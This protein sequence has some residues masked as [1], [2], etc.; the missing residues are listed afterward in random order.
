MASR[1]P[2]AAENPP[3]AG[4]R[5]AYL[6]S[7]HPSNLSSLPFESTMRGGVLLL[8]LTLFLRPCLAQEVVL[9]AA[10]DLGYACFRIPAMVDGAP[11]ELFAFAEGRR[12]GCADFGDVDILMRR[13][14]DGGA[15][16]SDPTVVVD[17]GELQAGNPTP[18]L[19]RMDPDHPDGRLFLFF[20][21]GTASEYDTRL[22]LGRRRGCFTT[23]TDHGRT[24]TEPV[25]ISRQVHFDAQGPRPEVDAR[26]LAFAPGH[27]LQLTLG[28]HAGRLFVPANHSLGPPQDDFM[29]YRTYGAYSDDHGRSWQVSPDL[30]LP[31]SNEAMAAQMPDGELLLLVRMQN[32]TDRRKVLAMSRDGGASWDSIWTA[33]A[34]TTPMCQSSLL[35]DGALM[36]TLHLGPADTLARTGLTMWASGDQGRSWSVLD[37]ICSGSAAYSDMA[38]L[39]DGRLGLLYE[40]KEYGEIVFVPWPVH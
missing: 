5:S 1:T 30:D 38:P 12:G 6:W 33:T 19:D 11:G 2:V 7:N 29:D 8:G 24:W 16:W 15:T 21:T 27:G 9:F 23:S 28:P 4:V 22:G 39:G 31:S 40:R 32:R 25:D 18:I 20:N 14:T 13:S 36:R 26:T 17:H 10:G 3:A 34:L 35:H 37:H